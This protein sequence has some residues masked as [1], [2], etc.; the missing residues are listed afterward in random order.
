M[1]RPDIHALSHLENFLELREHGLSF[2][3]DDLRQTA[4]TV[5]EYALL[6]EMARKVNF[7]RTRDG[8]TLQESY[9]LYLYNKSQAK[10]WDHL[11]GKKLER[12]ILEK[13]V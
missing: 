5:K 4:C 6:K 1:S 11:Y 9:Y 3:S 8:S 10:D 2:C 12:E 7:K 13:F